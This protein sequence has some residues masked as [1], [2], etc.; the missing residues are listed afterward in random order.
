MK[1]LLIIS[2]RNIWRNP[3]RSLVIIS[4]VM[5]GLWGGIFATSLSFGLM[6]Q[7]FKE[8]I[9]KQIS[10]IQIHH[11]EFIKENSVKHYIEN[12][13]EILITLENDPDVK[14]FSGRTLVDGMIS[15]ASL[16]RGISIKGVDH[17]TEARTTQLDKTIREGD[18]FESVE[19]NPI[20]IGK[21]LADK[22]KLDIRSRMVLTFQDINGDITASS[23]RVCGIYQSFN[24]MLDER[25]VYV[26]Q[27]DLSRLLGDSNITNEIAIHTENMEGV[28]SLAG[29]LKTKHPELTVRTWMEISPELS[30]MHEMTSTMLSIL[31][32]IILLALAFGLV[33]TML[34]SVFE[35]TREL[36]MLMSVGMNKTKV[37]IMI[38]L[39]T[40]YLTFIGAF[41]GVAGSVTTISLFRKTGLD[42]SSVGGDSLNEYGFDSVIYP[43]LD[44]NY[45]VYLIIFVI[46]TAVLSA[47]YPAY[48]A[49]RLKPAE[50]VRKE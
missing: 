11:P 37:F 30:Y 2:W 14:A 10:H 38:L 34:M 1:I 49:L 3:L 44:Y 24:S 4:S 28:D 26:K 9:E 20:L 6:D 16:T 21:K 45:F 12:A 17:K 29:K 18:Y 41:L 8:S 7:R 39:E 19:R 36:G 22:M 23:F 13:S 15:T 35:R 33:N 27:S 50:A 32:L 25:N 46:L 5:I 31:V 48:K 43:N 40:T 42:L 47:I